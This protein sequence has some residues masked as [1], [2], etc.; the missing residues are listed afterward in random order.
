LPLRSFPSERHQITMSFPRSIGQD[1]NGNPLFLK[2]E[3]GEREQGDLDNEMAEAVQHLVSLNYSETRERRQSKRKADERYGFSISQEKARARG[4]LVPR[5]WWRTETDAALREWTRAYPS[6]SVTLGELS[7]RGLLN[8]FE[9]HGSPPGHS[10]RTGDIPYVKVTDLKNW[11]IQENPTNFIS[12]KIAAKL[13][14]RGHELKF[15]D[16]VTPARASSNIGQFCLILPWQTQIVLTREVLI[17]RVAEN[18][19]GID[20][21]LLLAL[22]SLK[23]VQEQYSNLALMQV[24][25]DHLGDHWREVVIPLPDTNAGREAVARP[26]RDYFNGVVQARESYDKLLKIFGPDTFGTRP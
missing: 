4:V 2:N 14:K 11:R 13:R 22:F 17:L 19:E 18:N 8:A 3:D 9:G 24:N 26:V 1:K 5:F 25:R 15:G 16:L 7:D 23:V 20:P 10:R 12:E 6:D 21:F